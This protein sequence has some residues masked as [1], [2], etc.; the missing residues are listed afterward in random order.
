MG[1]KAFLI[2]QLQTMR[3]TEI[4][5]LILQLLASVIVMVAQANTG[6]LEL[7]KID[8]E[9]ADEKD[10]ESEIMLERDVFPDLLSLATHFYQ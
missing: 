7:K 9:P 4:S 5:L 6:V 1:C 10:P 2:Y 8:K 3:K